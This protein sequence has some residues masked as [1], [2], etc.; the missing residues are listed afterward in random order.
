MN[1]LC[2]DR[3]TVS[4]TVRSRTI[5]GLLWKLKIFIEK[6]VAAT[7]Y[8]KIELLLNIQGC[9]LVAVKLNCYIYK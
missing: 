1:Y 6:I 4:L 8:R 9:R 2:L 7:G 3:T 5:Q